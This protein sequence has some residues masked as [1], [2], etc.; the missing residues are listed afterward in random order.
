MSRSS[1]LAI[2]AVA[3]LLAPRAA[4]TQG[5]PDAIPRDVVMMIL[6]N[7]EGFGQPDVQVGETLPPELA[8]VVSLPPG[9]RLVAVLRDGTTSVLGTSAMSPDSIRAWFDSE[10][11]RRGYRPRE[12]AMGRPP[13]QPAERSVAANGYC[14]ASDHLTVAARPARRGPTEFVVRIRRA[15]DCARSLQPPAMSRGTMSS[16]GLNPPSLP[17]L[18]HPPTAEITERCDRALGAGSSAFSETVI[19]TSSG[20]QQLFAHYA[21]QLESSGWARDPLAGAVG[22]WTG[23]DSSGRTVRVHLSVEA[24]AGA[25]DCRRLR[26]GASEVER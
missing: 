13:F 18:Y 24:A 3:V 16:S 17:L 15:G 1:S 9:S 11:E 5:Q 7:H 12:S 26:L 21:R 4:H 14:S 2:A 20:A 25:P 6:R 22:S 10:F 23:R 19:A 8:A